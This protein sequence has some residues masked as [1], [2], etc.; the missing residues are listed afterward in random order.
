MS[1]PFDGDRGGFAA[2]D[3]QRG[4]AAL[5]VL[6]LQRVQ[7]RHDQPRAFCRRYGA[8]LM[9]SMPPDS[10]ISAEPATTAS[11]IT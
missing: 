3:A 11:S 10:T 2:A 8:L 5:Q 7:Q 6:R 1:D 9:L 4:N